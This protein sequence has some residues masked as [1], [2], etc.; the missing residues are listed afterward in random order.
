MLTKLKRDFRGRR[1]ITLLAIKSLSVLALFYLNI[2]AANH[3]S[4]T[5][6]GL[7][8]IALSGCNILA[9]LCLWGN[10]RQIVKD[11][12]TS[13]SQESYIY[14]KTNAIILL[15]LTI[16]FFSIYLAH[17]GQSL[18]STVASVALVAFM[19][20][21]RI[22][23]SL[24]K[25]HDEIIFSESI[26]TLLRPTVTI[27]ALYALLVFNF[28]LLSSSLL[29]CF[30]IGYIISALALSRSLKFTSKMQAPSLS[31]F[32]ISNQKNIDQMLLSIAFPL[33][34]NLD[35]LVVGLILPPEETAGYFACTRVV[36]LIQSANSVLNNLIISR[37]AKLYESR[38]YVELNYIIK[39]NNYVTH[40]YSFIAIILIA[41]FSRTILGLF[42]DSYKEYQA[43][44]CLLAVGQLTS[45]ICGPTN[46]VSSL[47]GAQ[48]S[49]A[50]IAIFFCIAQIILCF[51]LA[52]KFGVHGAAIST[53]FCIF[54]SN[55]LVTRLLR[56]QYSIRTTLF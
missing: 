53:L 1:A 52:S 20:F 34:N 21:M 40:T 46:L 6:F 8:G 45:V 43:L 32:K 25:A 14:S 12:S 28:E 54:G 36:F 51:L 22:E 39:K 44:L 23:N 15:M 13:N 50:R 30:G 42:G 27:I 9:L 4:E 31:K 11:S 33:L 49:A 16:P 55:F 24:K 3:S 19:C 17:T 26:S 10:E 35:I 47:V 56:R 18:S 2:L 38:N 37:I 29:I 41:F 48:K 7:F 5:E